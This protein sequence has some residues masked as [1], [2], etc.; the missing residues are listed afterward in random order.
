MKK[1]YHCKT[2]FDHAGDPID[3]NDFCSHS[4]SAE[5]IHRVKEIESARADMP[6]FRAY[7]KRNNL[8]VVGN[9]LV[10]KGDRDETAEQEKE[11]IQTKVD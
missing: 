2:S 11:N 10:S 8:M 3:E 7:M 6:R 4:C 5:Y 1:C 9:K